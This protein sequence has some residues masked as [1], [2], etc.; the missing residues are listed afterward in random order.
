MESITVY[1]V[2]AETESWKPIG[3]IEERRRN[4]RGDN[5]FGMLRLAR[6]TFALS[7]ED[8]PRI[9]ID[10]VEARRILSR[11]REDFEKG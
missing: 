9:M 8:E 2:D 11:I 5:Y 7:R 1:R 4:D 10:P 3:R 6:Q